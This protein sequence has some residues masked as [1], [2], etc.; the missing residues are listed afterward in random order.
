MSSLSTAVPEPM[1]PMY[2]HIPTPL[3]LAGE[4]LRRLVRIAV[5]LIFIAPWWP[6][7]LLLGAWLG[8]P[9]HVPST[10]RCVRLMGRVLSEPLS[11]LHPSVRWR[12]ALTIVDRWLQVPGHALAWWLDEL[13]Y[14]RQLD[15]VR[16]VEPVFELSAARS[17]STQLAHYVEDDPEICAPSTIGTGWPYMWLWRLVTPTIGRFFTMDDAEAA[18][19]R[20]LPPAFL[21]RHEF[22][23]RRTDSFEIVFM[24]HL[25]GDITWYLGPSGYL[26]EHGPV[27]QTD[28]NREYWQDFVRFLD[29]FGSKTLLTTG[30]P[31]LMVKGHFLAVA[32][33]LERL[34][35]DAR[36]LT[37]LRRPDRRVQSTLAH[38]RWQPT[39]P[40]FPPVPW[41]W[42]IDRDVPLEVEYCDV[43]MAWFQRQGG[44]RRCVIRFEDYVH[45]LEGTMARVYRECLDRQE[46][47]PHVPRVHAPRKRH[48]YSEDRSLA[49]LGVDTAWLER[50][51]D[52]YYRWC[53]AKVDG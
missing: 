30:R 37:V 33:D 22:S 2:E 40:G 29:R 18:F 42:I 34:Y 35:P 20:Q 6:V 51:L 12:L 45:D 7:Y 43:E 8:R 28:L 32:D 53:G 3:W 19:I 52:A 23:L 21:E 1:A 16:V 48:S 36:F 11:E 17:G 46:L 15:A 24:H 50:R 31:R 27:A 47:P 13:L 14:G 41:S 4:L 26:E 9:P 49:E 44:A 25:L 5:L 10:A 38:H 39:E